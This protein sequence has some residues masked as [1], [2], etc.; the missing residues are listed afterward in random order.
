MNM[1]SD[2]GFGPFVTKGKVQ[3]SFA[4]VKCSSDPY[5]DFRTS[6]VEMI[7]EKQIFTVKGLEQLLQCFLWLNSSH[8]HKVILEVFSEIW[9]TLFCIWS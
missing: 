4:V 6:M 8:L 1:N 2:M 7:V 9:E 5:K 3:E